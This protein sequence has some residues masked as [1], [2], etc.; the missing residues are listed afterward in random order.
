MMHGKTKIKL[1]HALFGQLADCLSV[2]LSM[3]GEG[4]VGILRRIIHHCVM[5]NGR[6][7]NGEGCGRRR[8]CSNQGSVQTPA[9][10]D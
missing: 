9:W 7:M 4:G 1:I 8:S 2:V 5:S 10:S 6:L 3:S